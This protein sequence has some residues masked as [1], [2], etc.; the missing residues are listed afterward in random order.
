MH[1]AQDPS[2]LG[3]PPVEEPPQP[4]PIPPQPELPDDDDDDDE[5]EDGQGHAQLS[6]WVEFWDKKKP[7]L[8][9]AAFSGHGLR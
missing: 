8:C 1:H 4:Q 6:S 5:E 3:R 7:S 2:D 9:A